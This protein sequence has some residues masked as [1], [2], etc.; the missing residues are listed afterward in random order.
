MSFRESVQLDESVQLSGEPGVLV[1]ATARGEGP[2]NSQARWG[3]GGR[4]GGRKHSRTRSL[5]VIGSKLMHTL[6][7]KILFST[8]CFPFTV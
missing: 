1:P 2:G 7:L 8:V 3:E 5:W 6:Y 4:E